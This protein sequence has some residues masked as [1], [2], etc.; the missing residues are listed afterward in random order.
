MSPPARLD[1]PEKD[2]MTTVSL[3][4]MAIALPSVPPTAQISSVEL[5]VN[6]LTADQIKSYIVATGDKPKP[7]PKKSG[8]K[9]GRLIR[10]AL[11]FNTYRFAPFAFLPK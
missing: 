10:F 2:S 11:W 7:P 4:P 9:V 8:R 1:D 6:G 5:K 3:Q